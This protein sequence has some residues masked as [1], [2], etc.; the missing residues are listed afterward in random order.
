MLNYRTRE[1]IFNKTMVLIRKF[2]YFV[3]RLDI[4]KKYEKY[5]KYAKYGYIPLLSYDPIGKNYRFN[6]YCLECP[7]NSNG[8][9]GTLFY[10]IQKEILHE[11]DGDN[12]CKNY[13]G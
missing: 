1:E 10:R 9:C 8:L 5:K 2:L 6:C 3:L 4:H 12:I 11:F 7:N 13:C